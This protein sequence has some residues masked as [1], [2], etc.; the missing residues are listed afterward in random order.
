MTEQD[1]LKIVE[2][3]FHVR[4]AETDAMGIVHHANYIVW[5]E[6]GRSA[7]MRANGTSYRAFEKDG[8][9]LAVSEVYARYLAPAIYDRLITVRCGI[10]S[11]QSRKMRFGYQIL[12][13]ELGR[14]LVTGYTEHICITVDGKV[15][16]IPKKWREMFGDAVTTFEDP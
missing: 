5:F 9:Q 12:D 1:P 7:F 11:A 10:E 3:S 14:L 6:E 2:I 16:R 15:A 4:Y 13:A 8:L